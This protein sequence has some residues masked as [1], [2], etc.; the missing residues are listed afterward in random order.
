[1]SFFVYRGKSDSGESGSLAGQLNALNLVEPLL[2]K[3]YVVFIH[4]PYTSP[5]VVVDLKLV[6]TGATVK[7]FS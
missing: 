7:S 2:G 3:G 4:N 5:D 1:M 6:G